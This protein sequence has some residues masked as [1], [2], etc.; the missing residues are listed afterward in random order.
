MRRVLLAAILVVALIAFLEVAASLYYFFVVP[1]QGRD[2]LEPLLGVAGAE[3]QDLLR[4]TPHPYFNYVFNRDYRYEDGFRPYNS[5]GFRAPEWTAKERG[6]IRIV[7]VGGSTTYRDIL[8]GR[9][10][11]LAGVSRKALERR[12]CS[13]R[14]DRQPRGHGVHPLR[15]HGRHGDDGA[16]AGAGHRSGQRRG[17]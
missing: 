7:A 17:Q 8:P 9:G 11:H 2:M 3:R 12:G 5:H 1:Q 10:G 4:Y 13:R 15:D 6:S 14:R 16:G